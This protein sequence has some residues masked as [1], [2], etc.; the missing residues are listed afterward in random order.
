MRLSN[1]FIQP[2]VLCSLTMITCSAIAAPMVIPT[3]SGFIVNKMNHTWFVKNNG[4]ALL[5]NTGNGGPANQIIGYKGGFLLQ[6]ESLTFYN[7]NNGINWMKVDRKIEPTGY[8]F[9]TS[10]DG[11]ASSGDVLYYKSFSNDYCISTNGGSLW[12]CKNPHFTLPSFGSGT[13]IIDASNII[14]ENGKFFRVYRVSKAT[15]SGTQYLD[16]LASGSS[17]S[18]IVNVTS[19]PQ[20]YVTKFSGNPLIVGD[21]LVSYKAKKGLFD[22]GLTNLRNLSSKTI[23]TKFTGAN[24]SFAAGNNKYF[25][26]GPVFGTIS[27]LIVVSNGKPT[28]AKY[29][30]ADYNITFNG[31]KFLAVDDSILSSPIQKHN[32]Y[33]SRNAVD[34]EEVK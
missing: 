33:I 31:K 29:I 22:I 34:W 27:K 20:G 30:N 9:P 28:L 11:L 21:N 10:T 4:T 25:V 6:N 26:V 8:R 13:N 18:K 3:N 32:I 24:I 12:S 7:S 23:A 19:L 17:Y 15:I 14:S 1:K 16:V 5:L 2:L